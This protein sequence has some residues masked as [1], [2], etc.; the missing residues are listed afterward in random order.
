MEEAIDIFAV[1]DADQ[2]CGVGL[3]DQAQA[4]VPQSYPI[5]TAFSGE[6]FEVLDVFNTDRSF[7]VVDNFLE[8]TCQ[9]RIVNLP[10]ILSETPGKG[11]FHS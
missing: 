1:E 5:I 9:R 8:L 11:E 2:G 6:F 3:D 4:I 10:H 7:D